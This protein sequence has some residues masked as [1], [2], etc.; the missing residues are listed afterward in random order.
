MDGVTT[1]QI[2]FFRVSVVRC[3]MAW[4]RFSR[5][6]GPHRK[7]LA[8]FFFPNKSGLLEFGNAHTTKLDGAGTSTWHDRHARFWAA[9]AGP[10]M[11]RLHNRKRRFRPVGEP[12]CYASFVAPLCVDWAGLPFFL[13]F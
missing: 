8:R 6:V 13:Y 2:L 1:H 7:W 12:N 10:S 5:L 11:G 9:T 4:T 3:I